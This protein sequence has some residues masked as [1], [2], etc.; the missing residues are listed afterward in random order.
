[1][2]DIPIDTQRLSTSVCL[3]VVIFLASISFVGFSSFGSDFIF[4]YVMNKN[5]IPRLHIGRSLTPI[6]T[7]RIGKQIALCIKIGSRNGP[8]NRAKAF[9]SLFVVLV[10]KVNDTVRTAGSKGT[11][12]FVKT[13]GIDGKDMAL[14]EHKPVHPKNEKAR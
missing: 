5:F 10:P 2:Y 3:Q 12:L 7:T 8:L 14:T 1:M 11:E 9:E 4:Q 6:I 13:N